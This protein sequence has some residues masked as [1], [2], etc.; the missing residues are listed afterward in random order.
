MAEETL[1]TGEPASEVVEDNTPESVTDEQEQA[2]YGDKEETETDQTAEA[3]ETKEESEEVVE[4]KEDKESEEDKSEESKKEDSADGELVL[5]LGENS[6][7]GETSLEEMKQFA[8]EHKLTNDQAKEVLKLHE[9]VL[10][11]YVESQEAKFV[12]Q[13]GEWRQEVLDDPDYGGDNLES[14]KQKAR[15]L[16]KAFASDELTNLLRDSGYGDNPHVVRFLADV[17]ASLTEESLATGK[18][19]IQPKTPEQTFYGS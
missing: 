14:T 16:V 9:Q 2:L 10:S 17:G 11:D 18:P 13:L 6:L 1:T 12:K 7:L 19:A 8:K 3:N 5:E 4:G 15:K